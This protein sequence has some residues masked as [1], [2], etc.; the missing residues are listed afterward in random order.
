MSSH[1]ESISACTTVLDWPSMVAAFSV[2]RHGPESSSAAFRNTAARSSNGS[3]RHPGAAAFAASIAARASVC[4]AFFSTPRT[5][6]CLCGWTTRTLRPPPMRCTPPMVIG[7]SMRSA[8]SSTSLSST[9][10]RSAL[11]GA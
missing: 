3:A 2:W 1:A 10:A 4:V 9:A 11:P 5:C 8:C 7:R 6:L